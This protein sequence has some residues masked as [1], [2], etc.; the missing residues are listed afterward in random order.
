MSK[1]D[2]LLKNE[3]VEWKKLGEVCQISKGKQFN[4]RD[5]LDD[6]TYPVING[7]ILP[8]GYID[9]FNRNENTITVSQGGAS[10]GYVNF[11]EEKFWLGAHAFSVVPDND[12]IN[13][14]DYEYSCFNRFLFHI[15]KMNQINL[16]DSK[17]GAGIPSVSKDRLSIIEVPLTTKQVQQKIVKTLDK[18]TNYVTELQ[19]EL[20]ARTKQYEYYRDMLLSEEYLNKLSNN[21]EILGGGGYSLKVT[22]LEEIV[23]IK[24]GKDW[25]TLGKGNIPVYGSGGKMNI[26][27]DKYSYNKP[28]V[29]IPRKGSIEN[30]FYVEE[31]FWNVDTIFYTE[32]DDEKII[33]KYLYYFIENYDM[34]KLSTDSTRPS[35]TQSIL[36]K[37][38]I[39]LPPI[40]IQNKVVEILDKFQS[41]LAD[42]KGLLPQE[43]EQRQKQYEYYREKLLTFDENSVKRERERERERAY[44]SNSY[45]NSL[46]E[47]GEIVEV[48]VFG[49]KL[50]RLEDIAEL[51]DGTHQTPKYV[52]TGVPFVSVQDIKNIY[53]TNKYITA[54]EYNKFKVKPRKNDVFMTRIGD[55]GTCAIVENDDDLAYYVTLTL[56]RP[57]NDIVLSKF[58]KYLIESS[59]GKKELSKR[60]LHNATP[61]K[62]NLGEIGKLQFLIPSIPVQEHIVSILD[63]FDSIVNDIS[64]GLPKEIELRQ[65]QYEH[66]RE[67]LL[68]FNR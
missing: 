16:Q 54:E 27:V 67:K 38:K 31:P 14:Y 50:K 30:V 21:P 62:I 17:E 58:L 8:S 65:K 39:D 12:I 68:S 20:Q 4:K 63:K 2:E 32:I 51:Y 40:E 57:S 35:L 6:G 61:I 47:A 43:I 9:L 5:M 56:I 18:F 23:K 37:V 19:A 64:K 11:I 34:A 10:A 22:T 3:K 36:N 1:I 26:F 24:N 66:Y 7:G 45:L 59:Q 25:K 46:K 55:I 33:P 29:L 13:E 41:L 44:L 15:L 28:S 42:T 53:G 52:N 60:I 49:V 48:S